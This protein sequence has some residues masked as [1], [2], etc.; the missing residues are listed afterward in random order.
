MHHSG[1][2][3]QKRLASWKPRIGMLVVGAV[4]A[5]G[6]CGGSAN[7]PTGASGD[8]SGTI[9]PAS[10]AVELCRGAGRQ[11]AETVAT[12][13]TLEAVFRARAADMA[14]WRAS[15]APND[16]HTPWRDRPDD[17]FVA[18]CI[19]DAVDI[20]APAGPAMEKGETR[21]PYDKLSVGAAEDATAKLL[22]TI[23]PDW[24]AGKTYAPEDY[25]PPDSERVK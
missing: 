17:Q 19:F 22:T 15:G 8:G 12:M 20:Q 18:V 5:L 11:E 13:Q 25:A 4:V 10:A 24:P 9:R 3:G 2:Y 1:A 16:P 14:A 6:A 7:T 21:P 23:R